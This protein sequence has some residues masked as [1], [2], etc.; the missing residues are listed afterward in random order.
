MGPDAMIL[1][2]WIL[3]FKP[4]FHPPLSVQSL[5]HVLLFVTPWTAACQASLSITNSRSLL[6][7][8]PIE[9]VMP[10]NHL[11]LCHPLLLLP[12]IFPSIRVFS[13]ESA[14]WPSSRGYLVPLC[15]LQLRYIICMSEVINISS[16]TLDS[17]LWFIQPRMSH[18]VLYI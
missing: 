10:L 8:M 11:I 6:K 16:G 14:L 17:N 15:F 12:S 7:L 13:S 1:V 4:T 18:D 5:S 2:F 3:S 9:L